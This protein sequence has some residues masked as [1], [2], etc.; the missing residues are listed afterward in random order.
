MDNSNEPQELRE[1]IPKLQPL[2]SP[3][4]VT[5]LALVGLFVL[6]LFYTLYFARSFFFPLTLAWMLSMLLKPVIRFF[7]KF[8][9]PEALS[10]ALL[11]IIVIVTFFSGVL[12]L[13][14]PAS[15]WI[16]QAPENLSMVEEKIRAWIQPAQELT[17]AAETVEQMADQQTETPKVELKKPGLLDNVWLRTKGFLYTAVEVFILLYFLLAAGD[18]LT[19]KV[20]QI[21]PRLSDK[22]RAVEIAHETE[23]GVSQYL[24]AVTLINLYEGTAIGV[25]LWLL[26]MPNPVLWGVLAFFANY[27][28]YIGAMVA[29]TMVTLAALVS[30]D[31]PGY[32]LLAPAIYFGVNFTDNFIAPFIMGRRLVLNPLIV[33]LAVMFWGW[34]WGIAGVLLAVPITVTVK[35][36][37]DHSVVLAPFGEF[38]AAVKPAREDT[39]QVRLKPAVAKGNA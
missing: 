17:A 10:A 38:L 35:I 3:L 13:S 36:L 33:F 21:L 28:P 32:A 15:R 37:C 24:L 9:V 8:H 4:N 6:A 29:G 16:Q 2:R 19:L 7:K 11:L 20:I 30:F 31:S 22:K 23:Q 27:I 14:D 34:L 39:E 5:A 25:G 26:G 18:L 1:E 12:L